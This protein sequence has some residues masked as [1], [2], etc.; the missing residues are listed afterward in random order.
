MHTTICVQIVPHIVVA[1]LKY[2]K[3]LSVDQLI[4]LLQMM[5]FTHQPFILIHVSFCNFSG[6]YSQ[7]PL[8]DHLFGLDHNDLTTTSPGMMMMMMMMI[9][10]MKMKMK[11]KMK[12]NLR[13]C[14]QIVRYCISY[15]S[16]CVKFPKM[17]VYPMILD[18]S[19]FQEAP[20]IVYKNFR[21]PPFI[22]QKNLW[23]Y[24]T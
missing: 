16:R 3:P 19:P 7:E 2:Y 4:I 8:I 17:K 9:M 5:A 10:M 14:Y 22:V 12:M 11:M 18:E 21:K 6:A 1:S 24:S 23:V 13:G 20:C 15:C